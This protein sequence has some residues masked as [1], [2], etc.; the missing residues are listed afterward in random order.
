M[1]VANKADA[2]AGIQQLD[3][4][5]LVRCRNGDEDHC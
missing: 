1:V 5:R 2:S 3:I 4:Q